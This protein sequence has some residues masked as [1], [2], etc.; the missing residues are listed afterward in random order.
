[1][2]VERFLEGE[3][4]YLSTIESEDMAVFIKVM[5]SEDVRILARSRR[6]VM[7]EAN[8]R[9]MLENLMKREEGF[10]IRRK[11]DDEAI[12]YG[13][14][15]DRDEYNREVMLA[16]TIGDKGDRGRGF[17]E[18]AVRLLLKHAFIDLNMES[19][20]L[21]VYEYNTSAI[22]VYEKAGFKFVGKRR[23]ARIIGNKFYDE[24]VMDIVSSEYFALY[25]DKEM[26]K[27][28]L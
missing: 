3:K 17:G 5:N 24:V 14:L 25:G 19:V 1:M 10:I 2:S 12:G 16:I 13:L 18:D 26:G 21:G 11:A 23:H 7:N 8:A 27:Y 28:G 6:D 20:H 22:R 4:I 15:M 9:E